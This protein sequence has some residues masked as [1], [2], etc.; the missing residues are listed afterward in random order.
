MVKA[1]KEKVSKNEVEGTKDMQPDL[2]DYFKITGQ[3]ISTNVCLLKTHR[4]TIGKG[5][6]HMCLFQ[7]NILQPFPAERP[8]VSR[9]KVSTNN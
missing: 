9:R 8:L 7:R 1:N 6:L 2:N 5:S 3:T 4:C